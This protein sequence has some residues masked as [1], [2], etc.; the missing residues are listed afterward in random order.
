MAKRKT[1]AKRLVERARI[2]SGNTRLGLS[3]MPK[4]HW[5][6]TDAAKAVRQQRGGLFGRKHRGIPEV[7]YS[8][9]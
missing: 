5:M 6:R 1:S 8:V 4:N 2:A 9:K 3:R 7:P